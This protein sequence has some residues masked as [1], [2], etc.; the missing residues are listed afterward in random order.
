MRLQ[1]SDEEYAHLFSAD[2]LWQGLSLEV[3][4]IAVGSR[5]ANTAAL[6]RLKSKGVCVGELSWKQLKSVLG[7]SQY[8]PVARSTMSRLLELL[9][10]MGLVSTVVLCGKEGGSL[11][12]A[13]SGVSTAYM[14]SR[15]AYVEESPSSTDRKGATEVIDGGTNVESLDT[16]CVVD[17]TSGFESRLV[18]HRM[19]HRAKD[20][21]RDPE[22]GADADPRLEIVEVHVEKIHSNRKSV[23]YDY[24]VTS[25]VLREEYWQALQLISFR[26]TMALA[27][28]DISNCFPFCSA[29][30]SA[31]ER[32]WAV[33]SN[34][35]PPDIGVVHA[36][37]IGRH[38]SSSRED[39]AVD[40]TDAGQISPHDAAELARRLNVSFET[41][42][43]A[44]TRITRTR[45]SRLKGKRSSRRLG[46]L[47]SKVASGMEPYDGTKRSRQRSGA[48]RDGAPA[49]DEDV[50]DLELLDL[51]QE[52]E[53]DMQ[54]TRSLPMRKKKWYPDED[55]RLLQAWA[56]F[57]AMHGLDKILRWRHV[58][59][60]PTGVLPVSCRNRIAALRR[61][62]G[63][64][65]NM[66]RIQ[67]LASSI[68]SDRISQ[69]VQAVRPFQ[70]LACLGRLYNCPSIFY[71]TFLSLS[72]TLLFFLNA[73]VF[74][75]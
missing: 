11:A 67:E 59:E 28:I 42:V 45:K 35:N 66:L 56:R 46:G 22:R 19:R 47:G 31:N 25:Q 6:Q 4:C 33:R 43:L 12:R 44:L 71:I 57:I 61:T 72:L 1:G 55:R 27:S 36:A 49:S 30:E 65:A 9:H 51:G 74:L 26:G 17:G 64:A 13:V 63:T 18:R 53:N 69:R 68:Y 23:L 54:Q 2:E 7:G 5:C 15:N 70:L 40:L 58:S 32:A 16:Q 41:V 48:R 73:G 24:D 38:A 29:P 39:M 62:P 34:V 21:G 37:L 3:L 52:D 10:R 14:L 60:R 8:L 20:D 75:R 50:S